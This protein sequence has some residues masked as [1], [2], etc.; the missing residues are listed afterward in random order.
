MRPWLAM[1]L[2]FALVP[3]ALGASGCVDYTITEQETQEE[4]GEDTADGWS[5]AT[6]TD[7]G[8][9]TGEDTTP[10][11]EA[12]VYANTSGTLYEVDPDDG[13]LTEIGDFESLDGP[14]SGMVDIAIDLD[15]RMFGGTFDALYR[16]DP[17]TAAVSKVCDTDIE[18]TALTFTDLGELIAGGDGGITT[19]NTLSCTAQWLVRDSQYLT[20]G[21]IVGLPDGYLYWTVEG[22][23]GGND[24]LIRV[25]PISGTEEWIGVTGGDNLFGVGYHADNLFGFSTTGEVVRINP[26]TAATITVAVH[27]DQAWWGATTNPVVWSN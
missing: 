14:V 22:A 1:M 10:I 18:F 15:G 16:I 21:D 5:G 20:S 13:L 25:S 3:V 2:P 12:P 26:N 9:D 19:V 8:G 11:P 27:E 7:T 24:E 4:G 17:T 6:S 23:D